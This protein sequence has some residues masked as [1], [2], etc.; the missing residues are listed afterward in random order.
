VEARHPSFFDGKLQSRTY[1]NSLQYYRKI[2]II[3]DVAGRR[4]ILHQKLTLEKTMVRFVGNGLH[5]TDYERINQ[6]AER[7]K[8]WCEWGLREVYFFV[9]EPDNLLAPELTL[10]LADQIK[11]SFDAEMRVPLPLQSG[12]NR[13]AQMSLF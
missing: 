5:S 12:D 11:G 2:A 7:L 9:H 4:D 10:Y 13:S 3:T 6:W 1:F 8:R